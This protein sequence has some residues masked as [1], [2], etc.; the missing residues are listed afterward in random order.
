MCPHKRRQIISK[1]WA[2]YEIKWKNYIFVVK[3]KQTIFYKKNNNNNKKK[4]K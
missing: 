4:N 1:P 2:K 3:Q